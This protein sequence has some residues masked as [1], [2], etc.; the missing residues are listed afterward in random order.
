MIF[1]RMRIGYKLICMQRIRRVKCDETKPHCL[2]CLNTGRKCD[3]Y[4]PI[5]PRHSAPRK[6]KTL[7]AEGDLKQEE[8][9]GSQRAVL[10]NSPNLFFDDQE[11]VLAFQYFCEKA[12]PTLDLLGSRSLYHEVAL[13]LFHQ[14]KLIKNLVLSISYAHQ[15]F[16]RLSKDSTSQ[17]IAYL[18]YASKAIRELTTSPNIPTGI[19]LIACLLLQGY[20]DLL[21]RFHTALT[22]AVGALKVSDEYESRPDNEKDTASGDL[23]AKY[24]LPAVAITRREVARFEKRDVVEEPSTAVQ[25]SPGNSE[26]TIQLP[27][28]IDSNQQV[29]S[30]LNYLAQEHL[31]R[32][33]YTFVPDHPTPGIADVLQA[34]VQ[35]GYLTDAFLVSNMNIMDRPFKMTA[36]V[37]RI[38]LLAIQ[39]M[40]QAVHQPD[41]MAYDLYQLY[42]WRYLL[43][44]IELIMEGLLELVQAGVYS[45]DTEPY[46]GLIP[47]LFLIASR[48]R[49]PRIR[50]QAISYLFKLRR[51]EKNWHSTI[52]ARI[53]ETMMRIEERDCL[54][55]E[56]CSDIPKESRIRAVSVDVDP[57]TRRAMLYYIKYPYNSLASIHEEEIGFVY[58]TEEEQK[59][60][61]NFVSQPFVLKSQFAP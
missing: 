13:P 59:N 24:V 39:N 55:V 7:G 23:I 18:T 20:E 16:T 41:E 56:D 15:S 4:K 50:R 11:T 44:K 42:M 54:E 17:S 30:L 10:F 5:E 40:C 32:Y 3:G 9:F 28:K 46:L 1:P 33:A 25:Y 49:H 48:C 60:P 43:S 36:L 58:T 27:P 2:R 22:H 52:A 47:G 35:L 19:V 12:V 51:Y 61:I 57:L 37:N 26:V 31:E 8:L 14:H 34:T 29:K 21:G 6:L 38:N 45:V 53:A